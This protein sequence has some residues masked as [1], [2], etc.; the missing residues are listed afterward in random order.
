V[1]QA[2][3]E[4]ANPAALV[5]GGGG[6]QVGF[7]RAEGNEIERWVGRMGHVSE[8]QSY[9]GV[10]AICLPGILEQFSL[11]QKQAQISK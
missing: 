2:V 1:S 10:S 9:L 11:R 4:R 8:C 5:S 6:R 7:L 3:L